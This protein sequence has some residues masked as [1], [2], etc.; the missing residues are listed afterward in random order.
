MLNVTIDYKNSNLNLSQVTDIKE[1]VDFFH[2]IFSN[3][4]G[5]KLRKSHVDHIS[6]NPAEEVV[7]NTDTEVTEG[8]VDVA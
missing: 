4:S 1:D 7:T 2:I 5:V 3:G 8:N 6:Y